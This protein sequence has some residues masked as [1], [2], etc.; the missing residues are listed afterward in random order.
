M[1]TLPKYMKG[2]NGR[3]DF[4]VPDGLGH[5]VYPDWDDPNLKVEFY[6]SASA[7]RATATVGGDP[8]LT[9]G[10]DYDENDNPDGG[11][12]GQTATDLIG[13]YGVAPTAQQT[14]AL[15]SAAT[16]TVLRTDVDAIHAAL[17]ALGLI[18]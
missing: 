2:D 1:N 12:F 9:Q 5:W 18:I 16:T 8:A 4:R 13:H 7:L 6:D 15:S 3:F 17:V 11:N 10:N 14:V